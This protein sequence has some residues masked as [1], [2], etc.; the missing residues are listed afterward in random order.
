MLPE[1]FFSLF[2]G[3]LAFE[4]PLPELDLLSE[5]LLFSEPESLLL[6]AFSPALYESLR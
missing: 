1:L 3:L 2:L 6:A 4:S 5:L